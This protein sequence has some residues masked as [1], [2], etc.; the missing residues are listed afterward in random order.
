MGSTLS[1]SGLQEV[2][3]SDN[4]KGLM[5]SNFTVLNNTLLKLAGI[6]DTDTSGLADGQILWYNSSSQKWE[7]KTPSL[8]AHTTTTTTV[9]STTTTTTV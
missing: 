6:L 1:P 4:H 2:D 9:S 3:D 5:N 7:P 8:A